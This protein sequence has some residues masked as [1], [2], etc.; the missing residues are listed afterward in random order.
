MYATNA[1][2][3]A[4]DKIRRFAASRMNEKL[5]AEKPG[6]RLLKKISDARRAW[7]AI[8]ERQQAIVFIFLMP[9]AFRLTPS[10][11]RGD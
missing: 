8:G 4:Q 7:K 11:E 3:T 5:F 2:V 1:V 6:R 10:G 9:Q